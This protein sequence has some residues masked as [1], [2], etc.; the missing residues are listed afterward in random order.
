MSTKTRKKTWPGILA[1]ALLIASILPLPAA[2]SGVGVTINGTPVAFGGSSGA[3]FIDSSS[4]TQVP[5]RTTMEAYGCDVSWDSGSRTAV[6][7]YNDK[8]VKVPVGARYITVN[9]RS[10]AI[11]TAA[12]IVNGRTYLPIRP[13]LEAFGGYVSW[14]NAT[15]SIIVDSTSPLVQVH[16]LDVGQGDSILIDAGDTEMLIDASV[17]DMGPTVVSDIKPY[18]DGNLDYLVATH[19][20]ADHIGGMASVFNA[21]D[22]GEV[23]ESGCPG[24]TATYSLYVSKRDAEKCPCVTDDDMTISLGASGAYVKFIETGDPLNDPNDA[25][26]VCELVYGNCKVVFTGDMGDNI[27]QANLSKFEDVNVL[28]VGHHGS[29]SS[30]C[31]AFLS[32]V[33]PEYA[34]IS[35]GRSNDYGH[36]HYKTL[37]RLSKYTSKILGTGKSGTITLS[38]NG[39]AYNINKS[40][41]LALSDAGNYNSGTGNSS[42]S[43]VST[44][45]PSTSVTDNLTASLIV[46]KSPS[47]AT[48]SSSDVTATYIANS[49]TGKF[50]RSN[51]S[52]VARMS[53]KNKVAYST[54]EAAIADGYIPCKICN[55]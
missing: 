17:A 43:A 5:L 26:V 44:G 8:T 33:R 31:E 49:N 38:T 48:G 24:T 36:P 29:S 15:S 14:D 51:C 10:V 27:E 9:G 11:D 40:N 54:R 7:T 45:A 3:P 4:R 55:P 37:Q 34:V 16:F 47:S 50:H 21:Y 12:Q 18:V 53:P 1:A 25:S 46:G 19:P 32:V 28:K 52:S 39:K 13:V 23:I 6:I 41:Y 2:A 20:D 22:I 35:Y 30:S 42:G